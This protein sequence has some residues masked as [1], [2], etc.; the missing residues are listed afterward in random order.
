MTA[1]EQ[2]ARKTA[3][4]CDDDELL[5]GIVR[6]ML[7][8]VGY[9]VI[10]EVDSPIEAMQALEVSAVDLVVLDLALRS[11]HG[12][13]I[14]DWLRSR[15]ANSKVVV[16]SAYIADHDALVAAGTSVT[17]EK[18]DFNRLE[19]AVRELLDSGTTSRA[20]RRRSNRPVT[21]LPAPTGTSLSGFEPWTS[22][23]AAAAALSDGDAILA[24]D[25]VPGD[26]L[27]PVWDPVFRAD[28][29]MTLGRALA[30]TKRPTDRVSLS[31]DWSPVLLLVAG[32]LEAPL[33]VFDRLTA[34]WARDIRVSTPVGVFSHVNADSDPAALLER[35]LSALRSPE[36]SMENPLRSI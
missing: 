8:D 16:F 30:D 1:I 14:L 17:I 2:T 20:E 29:R 22:L 32:R 28:H 34:D 21:P 11:G 26:A 6:R 3:L 25:V 13:E 7:E 12:E 35:V 4:V 5:R 36:T 10:A 15:G 31:P 18:P 27:R 23:T 33:A 19:E 24:L 9:Q